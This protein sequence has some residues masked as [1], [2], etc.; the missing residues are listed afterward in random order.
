MIDRELTYGAGTCPRFQTSSVESVVCF[1]RVKMVTQDKVA[2]ALVQIS[3][4]RRWQP[5]DPA[6]TLAQNGTNCAISTLSRSRYRASQQFF[7]NT[8]SLISAAALTKDG[9]SVFTRILQT[10]SCCHTNPFQWVVLA[11]SSWLYLGMPFT[12]PAARHING[13][14]WAYSFA[15]PS[16]SACRWAPDSRSKRTWFSSPACAARKRGVRPI[17][18]RIWTDAP[19]RRRVCKISTL[20]PVAAIC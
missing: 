10:A 14:W 4:L 17:L 2:S 1:I 16:S 8:A 6:T 5:D 11:E 20:G 3:L 18:L 19:L 9:I 7:F 13:W 12:Q 15:A